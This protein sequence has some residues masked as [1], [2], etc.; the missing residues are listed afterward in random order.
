MC[1]VGAQSI[2]P[3][4][5]RVVG[6]FHRVCAFVA[7]SMFEIVNDGKRIMRGVSLGNYTIYIS[8]GDLVCVSTRVHP[9][10]RAGLGRVS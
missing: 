5:L 6:G 10:E 1:E 9:N 8:R 4:G 2:L 3:T 7:S